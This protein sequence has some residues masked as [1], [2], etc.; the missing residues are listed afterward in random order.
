MRFVKYIA[1]TA[2]ALGL[3]FGMTR[4]PVIDAAPEPIKTGL[5]KVRLDMDKISAG[6]GWE[7]KRKTGSGTTDSGGIPLLQ[8]HGVPN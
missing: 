4:Q 8:K 6:S 7:V 2:L 3:F 5:Q 1:G